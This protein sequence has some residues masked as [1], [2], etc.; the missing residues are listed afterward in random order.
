MSGMYQLTAVRTVSIEV[1]CPA[2]ATSTGNTDPWIQYEN[3]AF[4]SQ[5]YHLSHI[6]V[7]AVSAQIREY[8][9]R[10][11]RT[12]Y[13]GSQMIISLR[14]TMPAVTQR[15]QTVSSLRFLSLISYSGDGI[16]NSNY[17]RTFHCCGGLEGMKAIGTLGSIICVSL[18]GLVIVFRLVERIVRR[19]D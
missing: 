12:V 14:S 5:T 3:R 2:S 4:N 1:Q 16:A 9:T 7:L 13:P 15:S 11:S 8:T 6:V 19:G 18:V 10:A 17:R